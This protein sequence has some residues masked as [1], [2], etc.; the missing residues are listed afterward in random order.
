MGGIAAGA[1]EPVLARL[2]DFGLK[3]GLAFQVVDDILD[4]T[5]DET[6]MGKPEGRDQALGKA[7]S[8]S[9]LGME[10]AV[11]KGRALAAEARAE[12]EDL[13]AAGELRAIAA[14]VG[15]RRN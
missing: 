5:G 7:T 14:L 2:R 10:E 1:G 3:L 9:V 12:L 11:R 13:P 6:V 15:E 8:P 4:M